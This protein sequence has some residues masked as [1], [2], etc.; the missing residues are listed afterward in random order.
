MNKLLLVGLKGLYYY[1]IY[2]KIM[3]I[4]RGKPEAQDMVSRNPDRRQSRICASL[5]QT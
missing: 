2:L 1:E 4:R 3:T 5:I